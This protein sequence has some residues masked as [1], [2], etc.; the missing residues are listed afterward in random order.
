[1]AIDLLQS[2]LLLPQIFNNIHNKKYNLINRLKMKWH[3]FCCHELSTTD[4]LDSDQF[5]TQSRNNYRGNRDH[6]TST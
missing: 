1:M 3:I 5:Q 6:C 4:R 2:A